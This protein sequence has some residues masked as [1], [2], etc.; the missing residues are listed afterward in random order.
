MILLSDEKHSLSLSLRN[1]CLQK[2]RS[3]DDSGLFTANLNVLCYQ[4]CNHFVGAS[5]LDIWRRN[6]SDEPHCVW[7]AQKRR[8]CYRAIRWLR[9][10]MADVCVILASLR[11]AQQLPPHDPLQERCHGDV[12]HVNLT[13]A[14]YLWHP[15][16]WQ[17]NI[18]GAQSWME[19]AAMCTGLYCR[20]EFWLSHAV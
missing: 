3:S 16:A 9:S 18:R 17:F 1:S 8:F 6:A 14:P 4:A 13:K 11:W 2:K 5:W 19:W 7:T 20:N 15:F 12:S 10:Q